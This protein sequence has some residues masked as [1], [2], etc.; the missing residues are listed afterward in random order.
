MLQ[1]AQDH[2]ENLRKPVTGFQD[3]LDKVA[4]KQAEDGSVSATLLGPLPHL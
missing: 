1:A 2:E 3:W 4:G